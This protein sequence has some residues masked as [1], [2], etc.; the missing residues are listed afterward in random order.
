MRRIDRDRLGTRCLSCNT[1]SREALCKYC[2]RDMNMQLR[3]QYMYLAIAVNF[4]GL[5]IMY[6]KLTDGNSNA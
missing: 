6:D 1:V 3:A 5:C 4:Y 2:D